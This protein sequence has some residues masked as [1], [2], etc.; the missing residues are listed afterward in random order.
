MH[1]LVATN[2]RNGAIIIYKAVSQ[3]KHC[4]IS[5]YFAGNQKSAA[6]CLYFNKEDCLEHRYQLTLKETKPTSR[7]LTNNK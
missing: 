3:K 4:F 1:R 7:R 2:K 6:D 5:S